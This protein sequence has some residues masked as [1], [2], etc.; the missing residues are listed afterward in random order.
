MIYETEKEKLQQLVLDIFNITEAK[1]ENWF[2][3]ISD[4]A[5][6]LQNHTHKNLAS[7]YFTRIFLDKLK[8]EAEEHI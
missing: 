8:A 4:I 1:Y 5:A 2:D 6:R 7:Q 3:V